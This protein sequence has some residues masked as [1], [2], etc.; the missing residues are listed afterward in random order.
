MRN[1]M[2]LIR[3]DNGANFVGASNELR[4]ALEDMDQG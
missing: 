1:S 2:I 4:K 3:S